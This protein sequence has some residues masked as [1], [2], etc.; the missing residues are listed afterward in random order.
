MIPN[1][2]LPATLGICSQLSSLLSQGTVTVYFPDSSVYVSTRVIIQRL[3]CVKVRPLLT[4][5]LKGSIN[6]L[7]THSR[8][9]CYTQ[10]RLFSLLLSVFLSFYS[11]RSLLYPHYV[12]FT[13]SLRPLTSISPLLLKFPASLILFLSFISISI[14]F[15]FSL[16]CGFLFFSHFWCVNSRFF[17]QLL[18]FLF[19]SLVFEGPQRRLW[20]GVRRKGCGHP[21]CSALLCCPDSSMSS[22]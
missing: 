2:S 5:K 3:Q 15:F 16:P 9:Q 10:H 4:L 20:R 14:Y 12:S 17:S 19:K 21:H 18:P 8:V 7:A 13:P 6:N 11:R 22:A 1:F